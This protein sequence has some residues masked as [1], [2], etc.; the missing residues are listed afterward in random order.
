MNKKVRVEVSNIKHYVYEDL[1]NNEVWDLI[2]DEHV[3]SLYLEDINS[4]NDEYH[5]VDQETKITNVIE[6]EE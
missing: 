1:D 2:N 5:Y 6:E 4:G 3:Q